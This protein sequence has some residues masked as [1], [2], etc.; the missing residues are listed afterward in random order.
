MHPD[1]DELLHLIR[2]TMDLILDDGNQ[3][4][5]GAETSLRLDS[6]DAFVVPKGVWHRLAALE[7]STLLHAT[8]GPGGDYRPC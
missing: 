8:P 7:P 4:V 5:V 6:G 1:G 2:G 3:V